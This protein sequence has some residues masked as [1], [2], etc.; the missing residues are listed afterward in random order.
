PIWLARFFERGKKLARRG[1]AD[2]IAADRF[3]EL[4]TRQ[5]WHVCR[6]GDGQ[7][8]QKGGAQRSSRK[9]QRPTLFRLW[10]IATRNVG[11]AQDC[12]SPRRAR[13][14][15]RVQKKCNDPP[16]FLT[17][18]NDPDIPRRMKISAPTRTRRSTR[19]QAVS[20]NLE[21]S[22]TRY[23]LATAGLAAVAMPA[24]AKADFSGYYAPSHSTLTNTA[25][26]TYRVV[27]TSAATRSPTLQRCSSPSAAA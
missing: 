12:E 6:E 1:N 15:E 11:C 2:R 27:D 5:M 17:T 26:S 13:R 14:G 22:L 3:R 8:Q 24:A 21:K 19:N 20:I 9:E 4:I 25:G 10:E 18:K 23:A 16:F 7:Y